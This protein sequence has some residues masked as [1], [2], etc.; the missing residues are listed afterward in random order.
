MIA[1]PERSSDEHNHSKVVTTGITFAARGQQVLS[2][3]LLELL[4]KYP[5]LKVHKQVHIVSEVSKF[6][7]QGS[8][9]I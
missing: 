9:L 4:E 1:L 3:S 2:T 8:E 6:C 5:A 7:G